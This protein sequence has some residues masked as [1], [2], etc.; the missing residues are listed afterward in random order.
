MRPRILYELSRRLAI[1]LEEG[2]RGPPG[3]P[4][5]P[6]FLCHPLDPVEAREDPEDHTAGILYP[7][8][9][10]PELRFRQPGWTLESGL[11]RGSREAMRRTC[12]WVR[13]R[14]L[15]LVA[16]GPIEMQLEALASA[17]QTLHD[18]S[19]VQLP[20][21]AGPAETS[22]ETPHAALRGPMEVGADTS[23]EELGS[24]PLTIVDAAE[25]WRELG[26][27]DHRITIGCE[28]VVPIGSDVLEPVERILERAVRLEG[29]AP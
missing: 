4:R 10:V 8:R 15:F 2:M 22:D 16:G 26:L 20:P 19:V 9:I 11:V 18:N 21:A 17:L 28:V 13:V 29:R 14:Y 5:V 23:A 1:L 25:G 3:S 6:V 7:A 27:Q 12:L 24:F